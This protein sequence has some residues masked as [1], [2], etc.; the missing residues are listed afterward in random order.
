MLV[1]HAHLHF[2]RGH[3]RGHRCSQKSIIQRVFVED[4][5]PKRT[6][7]LC[8]IAKSLR[9]MRRGC[10]VHMLQSPANACWCFM[11]LCTFG[12]GMDGHLPAEMRAFDAFP[13]RTKPRRTLFPCELA[14]SLRKIRR[15]RRCTCLSRLQT[16]ACIS[17]TFALSAFY[18]CALSV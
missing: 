8:G 11:H 16:R 12:T 4:K 6:R 3:G 7:F 18:A 2:R 10:R 13:W 9:K 15:G 17:G 1:F 14:T 5:K